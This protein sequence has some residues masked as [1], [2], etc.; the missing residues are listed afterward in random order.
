MLLDEDLEFCSCDIIATISEDVAI[1]LAKSD[2]T[3]NKYQDKLCIVGE[4]HEEDQLF[5]V[6]EL[7]WRINFLWWEKTTGGSTFYGGRKPLE[8]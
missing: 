2:T 3:K 5:N 7:H 8:D 1:A 4:N 6:G